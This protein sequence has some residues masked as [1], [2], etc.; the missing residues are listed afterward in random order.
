VSSLI[1]LELKAKINFKALIQS[2]A[3]QQ[4]NQHQQDN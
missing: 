1:K 4:Q 2:Y 3:Q